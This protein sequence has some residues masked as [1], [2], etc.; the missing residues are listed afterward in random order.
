ML[1][2]SR[3]LRLAAAGTALLIAALIIHLSLVP[4]GGAPPLRLPDK[5]GHFLAY[6]ALAAPLTLALGRRR[7]LPAVTC[8]CLL[9]LALEI[10][11]ATG[12]A[13]RHASGWDMLA[14][15]GGSLAGAAS[16]LVLA[17]LVGALRRS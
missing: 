5:L 2:L 10:A 13:G 9:G 8:T 14:N 3:L 17:G 4:S 1:R 12:D 15:L 7:W 6:A 16:V 11:Q